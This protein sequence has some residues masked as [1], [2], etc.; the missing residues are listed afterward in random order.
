[1]Q[2]RGHVGGWQRAALT[3]RP[4]LRVP[5]PL[6]ERVRPQRVLL[7]ALHGLG[8]FRVA[9]ELD[10]ARH[11]EG[12]HPGRQE[13]V[14]PGV[15]HGPGR[16]QDHA[17]LALALTDLGGDGDGGRFRDRV[18]LVDVRLALRGGDVL[19]PPAYRVLDAVD[20]VVPAAR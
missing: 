3:T 8:A 9:G 17:A 19:A 4:P 10:V 15:R 16:V 5:R 7:D 18:V 12:R 14:Q 6:V 2:L 13:T 1:L 11:H 20:E